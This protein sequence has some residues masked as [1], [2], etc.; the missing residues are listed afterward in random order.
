VALLG[1]LLH[2]W[3]EGLVHAEKAAFGIVLGDEARWSVGIGRWEIIGRLLVEG[4]CASFVEQKKL[5]GGSVS[6][7]RDLPRERCGLLVDGL[8]ASSC[9]C[10]WRE[11]GEARASRAN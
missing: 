9:R 10:F 4:A 8:R 3:T 7:L 11:A 1:I 5:R 2:Y 6:Q